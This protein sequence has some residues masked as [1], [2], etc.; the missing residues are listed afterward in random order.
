[1]E[2]LRNAIRNLSEEG[3][4]AWIKGL[5]ELG[6]SLRAWQDALFADLG[7]EVNCSAQERVLVDLATKT[8]LML[9]HVDAFL[10]SQPSL[11]NKS[12]R[13]LYPVVLQRTTIANSLA[14]YMGQLGLKRRPKTLPSP[15]DYIAGKAD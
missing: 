6:A 3:K 10:L 7:G 8:M 11:I 9:Q 15:H 14:Q 2:A 12:R 1:M 13:T 5:G 4:L